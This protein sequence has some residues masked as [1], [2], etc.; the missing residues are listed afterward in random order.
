[1][2]GENNFDAGLYG[3]PFGLAN[4]IYDILSVFAIIDTVDCSGGVI[5]PDT[6]ACSIPDAPIESGEHHGVHFIASSDWFSG[7]NV[8]PT[9]LL[10]FD[11]FVGVFGQVEYF[12]VNLTTVPPEDGPP[13]YA[14]A[15]IEYFGF[16]AFAV[17]A[18][19]SLLLLGVGLLGLTIAKRR[20]ATR[21]VA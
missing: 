11:D 9:S 15:E 16:D 7:T 5:D 2:P 19:P 20:T 3:N 14:S 13:V 4:G 6:G 8:L 12:D 17:P 18:P 10:S 21:V 1:M